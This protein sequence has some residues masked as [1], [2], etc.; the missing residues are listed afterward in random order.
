MTS[1]KKY[2]PQL[3]GLA[4]LSCLTLSKNTTNEKYLNPDSTT[5]ITLSFVGDLMCHSPQFKNAQLAEDSFDFNPSFQ[6]V[7]NYLT[8]ADFTIGNLETTC[9]GKKSGY[10]GYPN[11]NTP[12]EFITALKNAGFDFLVTANNH[13]MD[14]GEKG[15]LRT[16]GIVKKNNLGY[17]GTFTSK[18]DH[19]SIRVIAIKGIQLSILNYTYGTNGLYPSKENSYML[20][21]ID[22]TTI[23]HDIQQA[24]Y[25]GAEIIIVYYHFGIEN[26][27]EP[28]AD[29]EK[30]VKQTQNYGADII[31]GAHPHVIS[32]C[33]F[34]KTNRAKLD[35]GFVAYSLGNFISN[36]YW[37]YADAGVI[38]T[39]AL[40]K[41]IQADSIFISEVNF[42][43][44]WVYRGTDKKN[45]MHIIL[46]A[47]YH[48][49]DSLPA[50]ISTESKNKMKQT[51]EDTHEILQ[52]PS[53]KIRLNK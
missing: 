5:T 35:S 46:P 30:L 13:S 8:T 50:F 48:T 41:K 14:T 1:V 28:T 44:T 15:L 33:S 39:I 34:F 20:N 37:R 23:E 22:T 25:K 47:K 10:T 27:R 24:R 31:I 53:P 38:L 51:W 29:Q 21:I 18:E 17:T 49:Y 32:R 45:K 36:Q 2:I 40:T 3:I 9:A 52:N 16:I 26:N 19:D 7:K 43:P 42:I 12:D 6:E 11:F 4:L